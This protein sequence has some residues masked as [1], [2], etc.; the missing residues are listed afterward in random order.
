MSK[1]EATTPAAQDKKHPKSFNASG[2]DSD[3]LGFFVPKE[4]K[5][6][7]QVD[8]PEKTSSVSQD[9][10]SPKKVSKPKAETK[11]NPAKTS[12]NHESTQT[13]PDPEKQPAKRGRKKAEI[14]KEAITFHV[15]SDNLALL[16]KIAYV[17]KTTYAV[18]L[19]VA[20]EEYIDRHQEELQKYDTVAKILGLD[21]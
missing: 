10:N 14:R 11:H 4:T 16:K 19:N 15:Q 9:N 8:T 1:P 6:D 18:L 12:Q 2:M 5:P 20:I 13:D 21:P 3:L 7:Q 17:S